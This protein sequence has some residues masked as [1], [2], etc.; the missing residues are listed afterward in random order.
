MAFNN[1]LLYIHFNI[2][3]NSTL[4]YPSLVAKARMGHFLQLTL[5]PDWRKGLGGEVKKKQV[6]NIKA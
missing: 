1:Y 4:A 5:K 6:F 2:F 3:I